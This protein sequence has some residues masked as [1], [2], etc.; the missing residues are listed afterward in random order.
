MK[1]GSRMATRGKTKRIPLQ[2]MIW[3]KVRYW[4]SLHDISNEELAGYLGC[5][6]RTL[7]NYDNDPSS[8]TLKTI[9]TFLY[10][11][12]LSLADFLSAA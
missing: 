2:K 3:C 7:Q 1:G 9:D 6:T 10:A 4:Q 8:V 5:S 12:N 11:A